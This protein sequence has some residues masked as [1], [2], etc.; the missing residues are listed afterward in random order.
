M[1]VLDEKSVQRVADEVKTSRGRLDVLI[2]NAA[3]CLDVD[4]SIREVDLDVIQQQMDVNVY[5]PLRVTRAFLPLLEESDRGILVNISS[6]AGSVGACWRD[7]G[8]GYCMS[9]AALN[10]QSRILEKYLAPRGIKVLAVHPGWMQ[11]DMGGPG[12]DIPPAEAAEGI[13]RL[14]ASDTYRDTPMYVVYNGEPY[15][16]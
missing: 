1:D 15:P 3:L 12:A 7:T 11:S 16:Y 4:D 6:E 2:N 10:M 9:K 8:F 13:L 14:V 5:G